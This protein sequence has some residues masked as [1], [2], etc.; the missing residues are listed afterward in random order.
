MPLSQSNEFYTSRSLFLLNGDSCI[1]GQWVLARDSSGPPN[2]A[3]I[4]EILTRVGT[5]NFR[6]SRPDAILVR[7]GSI[8]PHTQESHMPMVTT[9]NVFTILPTKVFL[10]LVL[11]RYLL[12]D[13]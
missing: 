13:L 5:D 6:W 10:V 4:E 7:Y 2:V 9:G 3:C 11:W 1:V 12:M 8:G